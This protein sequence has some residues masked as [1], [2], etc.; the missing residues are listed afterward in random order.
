MSPLLRVLTCPLYLLSYPLYLRTL[1]HDQL[2]YEGLLVG[3]NGKQAK[4]LKAEWTRR[5]GR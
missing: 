2:A 5:I 3:P 1:T 4:Q